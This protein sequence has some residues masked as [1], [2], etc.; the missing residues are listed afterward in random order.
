M[1][2][3]QILGTLAEDPFLTQAVLARRCGL[4]VAMVNN[5]LKELSEAGLIE[6]RRK[7]L[8]SVS[9]HLT[10]LGRAQVEILESELVA[11]TI[12]RFARA[13]ERMRKRIQD[14]TAKAPLHRV[15]LYGSGHLT[16]M[17]F[18]ALEQS[19]VIVIGV[20][21]G[22]PAMGQQWCGRPVMDTTRVSDAAPDAV[23]ITDWE[24]T[25]EIWHRLKALFNGHIRLIRLDGRPS[26]DAMQ[27]TEL[28]EPHYTH[29]W[30]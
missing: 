27:E 28:P 6:F 8:K 12:A 4:S 25:D 30:I 22:N 15:V 10:G 16:E 29:P 21:T 18:H 11:D 2:Q 1:N 13:K 20:C 23:I 19:G 3:L 5:Y 26:D 7:S 17:V 14:Q 24:S 9:Y